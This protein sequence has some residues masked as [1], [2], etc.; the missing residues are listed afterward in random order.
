MA[1]GHFASFKYALD[2]RTVEDVDSTVS[3]AIA[4]DDWQHLDDVIKH[5]GAEGQWAPMAA[6]ANGYRACLQY[7]LRMGGCMKEAEQFGSSAGYKLCSSLW[8]DRGLVTKRPQDPW[9]AEM[10]TRAAY[11]VRRLDD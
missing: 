8:Y 2:H 11:Y 1:L 9:F 4:R 3:A 7:T 10:M 6:A 5:Q